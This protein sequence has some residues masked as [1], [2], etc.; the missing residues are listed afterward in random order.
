MT[1][2]APQPASGALPQRRWVRLGFALFFAASGC[3]DSAP[4]ASDPGADAHG[5]TLEVAIEFGERAF[6]ELATP[7]QLARAPAADSK[8]WHLA[9]E[10]LDVFTNG[11]VSGPGSGSA[12]GPLTPATWLWDTAPAVPLLSRDRAGGAFVD[13]YDYDG[14]T[15]QLFSRYHVYG[16]LDGERFY[17]V[18][19]LSYYG[20]VAGA[21][22]GARYH[23]RYAEVGSAGNRPTTELESLDAS[24]G[25]PKGG[26]EE[27]SICLDLATGA[28]APL[29]VAEARASD[30]WHV[31]LRRD[32]IAVNGGESGPRGVSAVDLDA[33]QTAS[34]TEA[35]VQA[36]SAESELARFD[37][38]DLRTLADVALRW[39]T[40]GIV[41]AFS[42]KWLDFDAEPTRP[43]DEAWLVIAPDGTTK[44][45]VAFDS[46]SGDLTRGSATLSLSVKT[47]R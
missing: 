42:D 22:V 21:P 10:G 40:D 17:K 43:T 23:L 34:E 41:T 20:E 3:G 37:A 11:G 12:F 46:L 35:E 7:A 14:T 33:A 8:D 30:A 32:A 2:Q 28:S 9:F 13:W 25:G 5:A 36:R 1:C 27:P 45:L 38:V 16:V 39:R 47:V 19:I 24:A 15:H 6:V 29:T 31:C 26:D 4:L 44:F 18:Q